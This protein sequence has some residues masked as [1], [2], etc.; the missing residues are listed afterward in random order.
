MDDSTGQSEDYTTGCL[1]DYENIKNYY[2]WIAD[3]KAIQEIEFTE[4]FYNLQQKKRV[5]QY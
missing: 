5:E 1:L 4:Q 3:Q 2:R